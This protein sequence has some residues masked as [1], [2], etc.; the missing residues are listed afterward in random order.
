[1]R[2]DLTLLEDGRVSVAPAGFLS[3]KQF[4]EY[5]KACRLVNSAF[6]PQLKVQI[7][8]FDDVPTLVEKLSES[9]KPN[10]TESL[11]NKLNAR[12]DELTEGERA[13]QEAIDRLDIDGLYP[14]QK[15]GV[16]WLYN[17]D[18]AILADEM[19]LGK[20]VQALAAAPAD[21]PVLVVAP[22][23]A[24]GVWKAEVER[25]CPNREVNVLKGN[26]L[27]YW[28]EPGEVLIMNYDILPAALFPFGEPEEGTIIVADEAHALKSRNRKRWKLFRKLV[29]ANEDGKVWLLTGTPMLNYPPELWNV[30]DIVDLAKPTFKTQSNFVRLFRGVRAGWHGYQW[31]TPEKEVIDLL[32]G[33]MLRRRREDVLPD[34][35][36][37]TYSNIEVN[38][39]SDETIKACDEVVAA[40]ETAGFDLETLELK[41]LQEFGFESLSRARRLLA[42]A[43][44]PTLLELVE[45]YEEADEPLV[46]FSYHRIPVDVLGE[47]DGWAMITGGVS[48]EDRTAIIERFQAGELKGVA[49]TIQAGGVGI[50][51]THSHHAIF[52]DLAWTP[53][54]NQQAEDRICRIGQTKGVQVNLLVAEHPLDKRVAEILGYKRQIIQNSVDKAAVTKV[55]HGSDK[56]RVAAEARCSDE[57]GI[58]TAAK[59]R[60]PANELEVWAANALLQL[61]AD[62]PDMATEENYVGF[63]KFDGEFGHSL[64]E[65]LR[66]TRQLTDKQWKA[67][68]RLCRKYHRQVGD[69]PSHY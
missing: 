6:D 41:D 25:W 24:K 12:A 42:S 7:V 46:V 14:F 17:R 62:D 10:V 40:L 56:F 34:L 19:G 27:F 9:F 64:A 39:L 49:C 16:G 13:A 51:L 50:T 66:K 59:F 20:T 33:N 69:P 67:A 28:P 44:V 58:V 26:F 31:G 54:A 36:D 32:R 5:L 47:R 30:L 45:Q 29:E 23:C 57:P 52:V 3:R 2:I 60:E 8:H 65:Q 35:P 63:N 43:K 48:A 38:N 1:M 4:G 15:D 53:A 37:K 68:I 55:V 11:A 61:S 18:R 22:A 21:A